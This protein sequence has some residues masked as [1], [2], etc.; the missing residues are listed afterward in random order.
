MY[1][2]LE[3]LEATRPRAR[4]LEAAAWSTLVALFAATTPAWPGTSAPA[5]ADIAVSIHRL[6]PAAVPGCPDQGGI[7]D[8]VS[9]PVGDP[10]DLRV[11]I[12]SGVAP[13]GGATFRLRS[14]DS[15]IVA[16]GDRR[17]AFLP[18]VTVPAGETTSNTFTVFGIRV[19]GT[20]LSATSLT[21]GIS[22]FSVPITAWDIGPE[23]QVKFLD[24][25]HPDSHCRVGDNSPT[26]NT[27]ESLLAHCGQP[28]EGIVADGVSRLLMRTRAGL[29]GTACFEIVSGAAA[30]QG[31]LDPA[32]KA[33]AA[34]SGGFHQAS[35][36]YTAPLAYEE[37]SS[38]SRMVEVEFTYTPAIGNGNTTRIRAETTIVRPPVTLIHG[39]WSNDDAWRGFFIRNDDQHTTV[40]GDYE[41][42]HDNSFS[43]NVPRVREFIADAV[44]Q[45]R[46]KRYA[47]TQVDIIAHS[48]G[49]L[50]SRLYAQDTTYQRADN[51]NEGDIHRLLTL[52]TPYFGSNFANLIVALHKAEP[53]LTEEKVGDIVG[54][55]ITNGAVCDLAENSPALQT[56]AGG[57][58]L[59]AHVVTST[60]GPAGTEADPALYWGGV[61]GFRNFEAALTETECVRRN[62]IRICQEE[63]PIFPQDIVDGHRFREMNDAI[64][65]ISSQRG[66]FGTAART[67]FA[68]LLH[69]GND[70]VFGVGQV[71][72]VTNTEAVAQ[73]ALALLNEP[74][75]AANWSAN[76]PAVASDGTGTPLLEPGIPG[77]NDAAVY[78][79]R[80]AP[81]GPLKSQT[82]GAMQLAAI[83]E[84]DPRIQI[85]DPME[86][87]IFVAGSTIQ[88]LVEIEPP[89]E[90]NDIRVRLPGLGLLEGT[91]Y[92]GLSYQAQ[93]DLPSE[94]AGPITLIPAITDTAGE[95]INGAPVTIAVRAAEAPERIYLIQHNHMLDLNE[96]EQAQLRLIGVY[97]SGS[98][99]VI[100]SSAAGTIYTSNDPAVVVT[101]SEGLLTPTGVGV[102]TV[103]VQH[104]DLTEAAIVRVNLAGAPIPPTEVTAALDVRLG[105]LRLNRR[106][107]FFV[108]QLTITNPTDSPI[109]GPLYAVFSG[110]PEEVELINFDSLTQSLVPVG[111]PYFRIP[112][113]DGLNLAP[114]ASMSVVLEFLNPQRRRIQYELSVFRSMSAP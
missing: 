58:A 95:R 72:G 12:T 75:D 111:S 34:V 98:H 105:A 53:D 110:L 55:E 52:N 22:G 113:S 87:D 64:V 78:A 51:L 82:E 50:L 35:S 44:N 70:A 79:D 91:N 26:F 30:D 61:S 54:G 40:A 41:A 85:V 81:G 4:Y 71:D 29:A 24:A 89:L 107:G 90:A 67:N 97:P 11:V 77:P 68:N 63:Q 47:T 23:G 18:E 49:G 108:Q 48:M 100:T 59:P 46:A 28:A 1:Y 94:F 37:A 14:D 27:D 103:A 74:A 60:G 43:D 83:E 5:T 3:S 101:D 10:L 102:T 73:R 114:G 57:T 16:A 109:P 7:L 13:Q 20:T 106:T 86:G 21:A 17:Q 33:T 2:L 36:Y 65:P 6:A 31:T 56:L 80:C 25:N 99:L 8:S 32:L 42:T 93:L 19:G 88:I 76:L 66:G 38:A 92:D 69:F 84:G 104:L 15:S 96:G 45:S 9:V 112:L 62:I 39:I